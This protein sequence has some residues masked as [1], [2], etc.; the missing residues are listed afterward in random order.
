MHILI[1]KAVDK[2]NASTYN[3]TVL[4]NRRQEPV[5]VRWYIDML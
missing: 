1:M 4:R 2:S 3:K 5:E